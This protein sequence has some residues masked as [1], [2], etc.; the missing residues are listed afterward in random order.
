[1]H[2]DAHTIY[3]KLLPRKLGCA[4]AAERVQHPGAFS[5]PKLP[6]NKNDEVTGK[7]FF[8]EKTNYVLEYAY[9]VRM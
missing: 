8:I 2:I 7:A 9:W 1:S 6:A 3:P 4:D 5:K